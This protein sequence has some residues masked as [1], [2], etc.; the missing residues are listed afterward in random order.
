MKGPWGA[1]QPLTPCSWLGK[2]CEACRALTLWRWTLL[3]GGP[4]ENSA[5][6]QAGPQEGQGQDREEVQSWDAQGLWMN[7]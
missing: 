5:V 2:P 3:S 7:S 1:G 6:S 4:L